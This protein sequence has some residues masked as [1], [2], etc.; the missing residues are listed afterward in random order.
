MERCI[1]SKDLKTHTQ[2]AHM[3]SIGLTLL[4]STFP[5][6]LD[7]KESSDSLGC[8]PDFHL[9]DAPACVP[10]N[11]TSRSEQDK[12]FQGFQRDLLNPHCRHDPKS[13]G[14]DKFF[15]SI[16]KLK[17]RQDLAATHPEAGLTCVQFI[18]NAQTQ[19]HEGVGGRKDLAHDVKEE[20]NK[21]QAKLLTWNKPQD[22]IWE[23]FKAHCKKELHE[24]DIQGF[25]TKRSESARS[26]TSPEQATVN[27]EVEHKSSGIMNQ[28]NVLAEQQTAL[29]E[30]Q[31]QA[32]MSVIGSNQ[33]R[34]F[35]ATA[36]PSCIQTDPTTG[37][38]S[39]MGSETCTDAQCKRLLNE[40][41]I[42]H[43]KQM[44]ALTLQNQELLARILDLQLNTSTA[45]TTANT[46]H[47]SFQNQDQSSM[48]KDAQGRKW[49]QVKF[50]CSKHGF[51]TSHSNENCNSKR[52]TKGHPWTPGATPAN[53]KGGSNAH[54]DKFNHW[55]EPRAKQHSPQP[56]N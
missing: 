39:A 17:Q 46:S 7:L 4:S 43:G 20:W 44:D 27:S 41:Q 11:T 9:K 15:K 13:N 54:A 14:I 50:H 10:D 29:T 32:A 18:N 24:L 51:N 6:C 22:E 53:A 8:P 26:V 56:P 33:Q 40:Q 12:E 38:A 36:I 2:A 5:N 42:H 55:Y 25:I 23:N 47:S 45:A 19:V 31:T 49:H 3:K 30:Q 35:N 28:L 52:M 1:H 37:N 34:A 21:E 48:K 16:Q